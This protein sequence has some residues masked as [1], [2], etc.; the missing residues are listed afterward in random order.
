[1]G[2]VNNVRTAQAGWYCLNLIAYR[3]LVRTADVSSDVEQCKVVFKSLLLDEL[4]LTLM[5]S[6]VEQCKVVSKSLLLDELELTLS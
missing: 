4:E 3:F 6:D 5:S 2:S 1:M